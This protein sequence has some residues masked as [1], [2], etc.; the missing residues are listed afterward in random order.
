[1][2]GCEWND[3]TDT[4]KGYDQFGYDGEDF[5]TFDQE[6]KTWIAPRP[7]AFIT[8]LKWDQEAANIAYW[9]NYLTQICPDW[10]K[11]YVSFG[12][13]TLTRKGKIN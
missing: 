6:T 1:M 10:L 11:K 7:E 8:K 4:V 3:E 12:K 9:T 2:Y 13:S 5:I